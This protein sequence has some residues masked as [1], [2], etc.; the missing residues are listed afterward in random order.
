[1]AV[2]NSPTCAGMVGSDHGCTARGF[3]M[4]IHATCRGSAGLAAQILLMMR[5][6]SPCSWYKTKRAGA[7]PSHMG[8][9]NRSRATLDAAVTAEPATAGAGNTVTTKSLD[10]FHEAKES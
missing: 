4:R 9:K 5:V 7:T 8:W 10:S 1:M 6:K 3:W 2:M